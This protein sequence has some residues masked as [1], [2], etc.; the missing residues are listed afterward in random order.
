M[1]MEPQSVSAR[2]KMLFVD[3]DVFFLDLYNR[4]A[5]QY[6]IEMKVANGAEA[7]F[8]KLEEGFVPELFVVDLDMPNISGMEFIQELHKRGITAKSYIVILTN[9]NDPYYMEKSK[10]YLVDRYIVKAT[11]VPS[12]VMEDLLDLL[13]SGKKKTN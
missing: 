2:P 11:R 6:N 3:D 4:K 1:Y 8:K 10:E 5:E 13:K 12:E 9:K 7:A